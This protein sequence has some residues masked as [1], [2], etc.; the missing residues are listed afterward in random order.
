MLGFV[1][2]TFQLLPSLTAIENVMLPLELAAPPMP[3]ARLS[4]GCSGSGWRTA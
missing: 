4:A 3:A 1:F 2:Q